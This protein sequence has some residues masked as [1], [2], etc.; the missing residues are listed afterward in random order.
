MFWQKNNSWE[1]LGTITIH[2]S[3]SVEARM[4]PDAPSAQD[5]PSQQSR[6]PPNVDNT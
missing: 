4:P 1:G 5:S 6:V 3:H 2:H